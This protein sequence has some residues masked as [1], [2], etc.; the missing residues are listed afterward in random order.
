M[1]TISGAWKK[2]WP[3]LRHVNSSSGALGTAVNNT[4]DVLVH[5]VIKA[6]ADDKTRE[7]SPIKRHRKFHSAYHG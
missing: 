5:V 7:S 3:A 4:M 6:P 2:L 1:L